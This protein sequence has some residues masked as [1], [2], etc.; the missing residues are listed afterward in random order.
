MKLTHIQAF[1]CPFGRLEFIPAQ[2]GFLALW[3]AN[4]KDTFR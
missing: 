3:R 4:G 2:P 1:T